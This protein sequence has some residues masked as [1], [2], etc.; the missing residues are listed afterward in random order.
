M[1]T[2]LPDPDPSLPVILVVEDHEQVRASLLAWLSV[3]FPQFRFI[4]AASGEQAL[5]LVTSYL[6]RLVL[7][8]IGL[9]GMSGLEAARTILHHYPTI[10]V[11]MLSIHDEA[12]YRDDARQLGASGF[13]AK[14]QMRTSLIPALLQAL[15]P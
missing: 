11:V 10:K 4:E 6:P 3:I 9:P 12:S 5:E 8:D 15:E 2:S 13:V 7:M 1:T 14:A